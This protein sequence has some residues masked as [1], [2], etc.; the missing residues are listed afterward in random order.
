MDLL[1]VAR[2]KETIRNDR[3]RI[4]RERALAGDIAAA[5]IVF[6]EAMA[7]TARGK[8]SVFRK[9][10]SRIQVEELVDG[11]GERCAACFRSMDKQH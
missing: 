11:N 3:E 6:V 7:W 5:K 4:A 8:R 10:R 9:S 2:G 1:L